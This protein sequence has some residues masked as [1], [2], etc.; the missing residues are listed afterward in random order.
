[1][2]TGFLRPKFDS[3]RKQILAQLSQLGYAVEVSRVN[4]TEAKLPQH[5]ERCFITGH[6]S[7]GT[8][9]PPPRLTPPTLREALSDLGEPNGVNR[10]TEIGIA[11]TYKGHRP[12]LLD[13]VAHTIRHGGGHGPGG[14]NNTLQTDNGRVRYFTIAELARIQGFPDDHQFDPVWTHAQ[15]EL[16]NACPPP[17]ARLWLRQLQKKLPASMIPPSDDYPE[18]LYHDS[19]GPVPTAQITSESEP[20]PAVDSLLP[21]TT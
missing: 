17:L 9:E 8:I 15:A 2:V 10:H 21:T 4:A 18:P 20:D 1:M 5:R 16:G 19:R 7:L 6:Q 11:K 3:F 14:G 13:G 12:S